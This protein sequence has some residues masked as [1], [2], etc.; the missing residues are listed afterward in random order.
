MRTDDLAAFFRQASNNPALG[1]IVRGALAGD[2]ALPRLVEL[3]AQHGYTVGEKEL[4]REL[5][6]ALGSQWRELSGSDL[7]AVAGGAAPIRKIGG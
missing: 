2:E 5:Q 6:K 1:K 4:R 3:A 7:D